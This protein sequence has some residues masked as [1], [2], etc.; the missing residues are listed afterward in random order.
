MASMEEYAEGSMTIQ[1]TW[2][3]QTR[4]TGGQQSNPGLPASFLL[5]MG[6]RNRNSFCNSWR[7]H[8][9]SA[10]PMQPTVGWTMLHRTLWT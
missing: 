10:K 6:N 4:S 9:Y 8:F 2:K 5:Q 7:D 3:Q 1:H